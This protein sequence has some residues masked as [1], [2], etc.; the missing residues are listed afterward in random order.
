MSEHQHTIAK[1]ERTHLGYEDHGIFSLTLHFSYGGSGQ[2]FGPICLGG[3]LAASLIEAVLKA[4]GVDSWEQLPGRTLYAVRGEGWNGF[5][6]G[7]APLPTERGEGFLLT[8]EG[9]LLPYSV[10]RSDG[11]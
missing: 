11:E 5:V 2:G 6:R 9:E 4:A 7:L 8:S 1:I 10:E 3:E